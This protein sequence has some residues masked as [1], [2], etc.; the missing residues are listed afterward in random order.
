MI[1]LVSKAF[2]K[3]SKSKQNVQLTSFSFYRTC[4]KLNSANNNASDQ[5]SS[6]DIDTDKRKEYG[7]KVINKYLTNC[8]SVTENVDMYETIEKRQIG[9]SSPFIF[10]IEKTGCRHGFSRAFVRYPISGNDTKQLGQLQSGMLRLS[11]PL[12]VKEIDQFE[13]SGGIEQINSILNHTSKSKISNHND[14]KSNHDEF[15]LQ[16]N[17]LINNFHD[18]NNAWKSI[19]ND[20]STEYDK[21][22]VKEYLGDKFSESF[23]NSGIIGV[24]QGKVDDA[25]CLHAHG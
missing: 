10:A 11:C 7:D 17:E 25:K 20:I 14:E 18:V 4:L 1:L 12:L 16:R 3:T 22:Y 6:I 24:S 9:V 5:T 2:L 15:E 23:F 19:R 21:A 8:I 13:Q